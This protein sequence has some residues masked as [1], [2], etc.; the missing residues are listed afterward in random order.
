MF[1]FIHA[2]DIHLD[3]PLRGLDK[4]E[5]APVDAIRGATR[6][7]F[8]NLVRLAIDERVAFV[9][10]AGDIYD[11]DWQ[12]YNTGL[13]FVNELHKLN[14]AGIHVVTLRGN[15]DAKHDMTRDLKL[16]DNAELYRLPIDKPGTVEFKELRV[17]IHGQGYANK[18]ELRNLAADYPSPTA[19]FFNIG[20]LH[21]A[22]E[23]REGHNTYARCTLQELVALGYDYWALG[24][25]HKRS[26]ENGKQHPRVEFP[27][28]LQ[29]RDIGETGAKG[30]LLVTVDGNR[31]NPEFHAMD[32]FRW[33]MV[34]V[35]A[36]DFESISDALDAAIAAL[37]DAKDRAEGRPLG[38]RI[39]ISCRDALRRQI[40][41]H[42]E[43]FRFD[44][45]G[46]IGSEVWVEKI[47]L[48]PVDDKPEDDSKLSGDALSELKAVL[49]DL[50]SDP[51]R[52]DAVF[53]S[54]DCEKLKKELR[55]I[56]RYTHEG[57]REDDS[58]D[59]EIFAASRGDI[60]EMAERLLHGADLSE[61]RS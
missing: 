24:H 45:A 43:E 57:N 1:K 59:G 3:S 51:V 6:K 23:G 53:T 40:A 49:A 54:A 32:E 18:T 11:G 5:G 30:C 61:E 28:N 39:V 4:Y 27:G 21:T 20:V 25:V 12:D 2:A 50:Q 19:G 41:K 48:H 36:A 37:T 31:A 7:A 26:S 9:I 14:K 52:A 38:A 42:I 44:L 15:H 10:L 60:F 22:L 33:D 58:E 34:P 16:P 46:Q 47:K 55:K 56:A 29:G 13:F 35:D 8:T 17:A